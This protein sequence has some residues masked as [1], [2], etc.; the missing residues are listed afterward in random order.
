MSYK[1]RFA[2]KI[3]QFE[4]KHL[5]HIRF[6]KSYMGVKFVLLLPIAIILFTAEY[7]NERFFKKDSNNPHKELVISNI[8]A[9]WANLAF[10]DPKVE[11]LAKKRADIC[12]ACPFAVF[13][14]GIHTIVVDNKTTQVRGLKCTKCGCPLSAK[15]RSPH[16]YCPLG[17]W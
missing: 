15:V 10:T 11:E 9:G 12:A 2:K 17:E 1:E 8:I 6:K 3:R 5:P 7:I 4:R 13:V 16:D 14:G